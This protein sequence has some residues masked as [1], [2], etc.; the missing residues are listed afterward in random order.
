MIRIN[1]LKLKALSMQAPKDVDR[2]ELISYVHLL[3]FGPRGTRSPR[4]VFLP[5]KDIARMVR[6]SP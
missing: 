1:L 2:Q 3:R 4:R 5:I 6:V